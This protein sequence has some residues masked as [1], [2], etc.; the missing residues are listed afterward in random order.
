MDLYFSNYRLN[1]LAN[2]PTGSYHAGKY[3]VYMGH[4]KTDNLVWSYNTASM[5]DSYFR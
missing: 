4:S 5:F 1:L 2:V 3:R